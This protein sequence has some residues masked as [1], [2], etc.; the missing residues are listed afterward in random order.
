MLI[1]FLRLLALLLLNVTGSWVFGEANVEQLFTLGIVIS[2]PNID[3]E[4]LI[5]EI[6]E[7]YQDPYHAENVSLRYQTNYNKIRLQINPVHSSGKGLNEVIQQL[8]CSVPSRGTNAFLFLIDEHSHA[9]SVLLSKFMSTLATN[10]NLPALAWSSSIVEFEDSTKFKF[11][12]ALLAPSVEHQAKATFAFLQK[13]LN[14]KRV[15]LMISS[16]TAGHKS[17]LRTL[18]RLSEYHD[19]GRKY[20]RFE[21]D[22]HQDHMSS[23]FIHVVH[24]DNSSMEVIRKELMYMRDYTDSRVFVLY[25]DFQLTDKIMEEANL[26]GMTRSEFIWILAKPAFVEP[27][28]VNYAQG[29]IAMSYDTSYYVQMMA[30]KA[31]IRIW[32]EAVRRLLLQYPDEEA[33]EPVISCTRFS[34]DKWKYGEYFNQL[35]V[36]RA[37]YAAENEF[38]ALKRIDFKVVQV[39]R[40]WKRVGGWSE[41]NGV[42]I[43]DRKWRKNF[44]AEKLGLAA[45]NFLR[46]VTLDETPYINYQLPQSDGQCPKNSISCRLS[47]DR[48][49]T[50][51]FTDSSNQEE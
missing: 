49:H 18:Q 23:R 38:R 21:F 32:S 6:K 15:T 8:F 17:Y 22:S 11:P 46:I 50:H 48:I 39:S 43:E 3:S 27:V 28:P 4:R 9:S 36:K 29:V 1:L 44:N 16:H 51:V 40:H 45:R 42:L 2:N 41:A 37:A 25:C 33:F 26:L 34:S 10:I 35:V 47:D 13:L 31:G 20:S 19:G 7:E 5:T 30:L 14:Q 12:M 24:I